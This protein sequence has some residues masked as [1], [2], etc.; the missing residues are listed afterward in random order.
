M[1]RK[2]AEGLKWNVNNYIR[3]SELF[4][5]TDKARIF[6]ES[7]EDSFIHLYYDWKNGGDRAIKLISDTYKAY[8]DAI[9]SIEN[10]IYPVIEGKPK[11]YIKISSTKVDGVD[12][13]KIELDTS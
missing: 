4:G 7:T 8:D 6:K 9:A 11:Q 10:G 1:M 12:K 13:Y 5:I 3:A 2:Y